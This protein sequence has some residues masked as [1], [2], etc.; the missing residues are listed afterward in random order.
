[1]NKYGGPIWGALTSSCNGEFTEY[2]VNMWMY[3]EKLSD[4]DERT[5]LFVTFLFP[6]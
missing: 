2:F 1:M 6:F 5:Y 4:R 3:A